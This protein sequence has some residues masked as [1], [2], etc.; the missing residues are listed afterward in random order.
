ME[1]T[2]ATSNARYGLVAIGNFTNILEVIPI[3]H[4]TPEGMI[5]GLKKIVQSMGEP[6]QLYSD[7][8][9]SMRSSKMNIFLNDNEV[10][11]IQ[12]ATHAH[13]VERAVRTFKDNLYRILNAFKQ[14]NNEWVTHISSIIKTH[15]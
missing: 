13:A 7:E 14:D 5:I 4:R 15:N 8:G 9:S 11:S 6:K 12:T 3:K 2:Y 10:K 1:S